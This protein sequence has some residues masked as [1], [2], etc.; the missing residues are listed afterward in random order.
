MGLRDYGDKHFHSFT[1]ILYTDCG[2]A[3]LRWKAFSLFYSYLIYWLWDCRTAVAGIFTLS[4]ISHILTMGLR[5]C[6]G[7]HF[8][9]F[10]LSLINWLWN[11]GTVVAGMFRLSLINYFMCWLWDCGGWHFC[12]S[13][14]I[15]QLL[16]CGGTKAILI[17]HYHIYIMT[18]GPRTTVFRT[19]RCPSGLV[20]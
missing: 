14:I 10:T 20:L 7:R 16:D 8:H 11:C 2:T 1:H 18:T 6:G 3:G 9:S 13:L 5:D 12:L 19:Q 17:F 15:N 4:L